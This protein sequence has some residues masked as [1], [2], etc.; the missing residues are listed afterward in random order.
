[1]T[2]LPP[3]AQLGLPP[4]FSAPHVRLKTLAVPVQVDDAG[5]LADRDGATRLAEDQ[6]PTRR[7][8]ADEGRAIGLDA[9]LGGGG[10]GHL[11]LRAR[12]L[13]TPSLPLQSR[14]QQ[15]IGSTRDLASTRS[16]GTGA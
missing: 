15:R 7:L 10:V 13:V 1:M 6:I 12:P 8:D 2:G 16:E 5:F 14:E 4:P 3:R 9:E 11:Q